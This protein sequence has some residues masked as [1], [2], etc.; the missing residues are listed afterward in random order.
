MAYCFLW[1]QCPIKIHA[2]AME[3]ELSQFTYCNLQEAKKCETSER[4]KDA[5]LICSTLRK[6]I[7]KISL[8]IAALQK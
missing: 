4:N 2:I 6:R 8:S 3:S 1:I 7:K 5:N